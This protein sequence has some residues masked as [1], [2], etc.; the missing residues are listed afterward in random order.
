MKLRQVFGTLAC[1]AVLLAGAGACSEDI[2][3]TADESSMSAGSGVDQDDPVA[4]LK[5]GIEQGQ[6]GKSDEAKTTF[7]KVLALQGDNKFAWFNLGYLAQSRSATAEAM[8]SYDMALQIDG[9]YWPAMY[10]KAILLEESRPN[11]AITLYRKIVAADKNASTA[12]LRLG[13]LLDKQK[14]REGARVA[15]ASAVAADASLASAVPAGYRSQK[16]AR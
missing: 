5:Q 2:G 15:F 13:L 9:S 14:D 7:E 8:A 3:P 4:L 1:G 11:E 16:S 12:Y 6:A 10:N